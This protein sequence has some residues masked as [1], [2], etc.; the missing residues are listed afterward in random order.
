M[1]AKDLVKQLTE[2]IKKHGNLK[3]YSEYDG[4]CR[5]LSSN[6]IVEKDEE[7]SKEL[8]FVIEEE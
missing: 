6:V 2:L 7:L 5:T 1:K 4:F 3:V 8:I